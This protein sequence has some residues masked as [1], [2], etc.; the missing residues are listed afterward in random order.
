MSSGH[1]ENCLKS[2][3]SGESQNALSVRRV[4]LVANGPFVS[5]VPS[6][7]MPTHQSV[8]ALQNSLLSALSFNGSVTGCASAAKGRTAEISKADT[9][10]TVIPLSARRAAE[11]RRFP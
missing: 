11:G 4:R 2:G 6:V 3:I 9:F 10:V 5:K 8:W 1:T 7:L